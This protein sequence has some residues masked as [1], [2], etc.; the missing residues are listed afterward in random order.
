M[1]FLTLITMLVSLPL[2]AVEVPENLLDAISKVESN[3]N[4][5][6][7]GDSGNAVGRFQIWKS[8]VDEVNRISR[9][10]KTGVQFDYEDRV[11]AEKSRQMVKIYL[12][13]WGKQYE[14]NTGKKAG[15]ETL[16]KIHNGHAFWKRSRVKNPKYF[17]RIERYWGRVEKCVNS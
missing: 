6:A 4:D 15:L 16:A 12:N 9:I 1:K 7:I 3:G 14:K 13:F 8:Y 17:E 2:M 5:S 11:N 10:Q